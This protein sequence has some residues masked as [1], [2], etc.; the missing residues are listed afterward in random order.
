MSIDS[1]R[2]QV[3]LPCN[4]VPPATRFAQPV[5]DLYGR[6]RVQTARP[7]VCLPSNKTYVVRKTQVLIVR[8]DRTGPLKGRSSLNLAVKYNVRY[9]EHL[10]WIMDYCT[11]LVWGF[12]SVS[13]RQT[14]ALLNILPRFLELPVSVQALCFAAFP[15]QCFGSVQKTS[16]WFRSTS[17]DMLPVL[18]SYSSDGAT[19]FFAN[20]YI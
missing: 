15:D 6:L 11:Q 12:V 13:M 1:Q 17:F 19:P 14:L 20:G 18:H 16:T 10:Q 5:C 9:A 4:G 7:N 3:P 2:T 8:F